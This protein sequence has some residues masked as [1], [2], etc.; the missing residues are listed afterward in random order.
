MIGQG[1]GPIPARIPLSLKLAYSA[2][3]A[4]LLPVYLANYG[5]TNFLYFCDIA[6]ILT[7][8][9]IWAES[10]LLVSI[11]AVG[12]LA[13]QLL[14]AVDFLAQAAGTPLTGMTAYMF[15]PDTSLFLRGL[16]LFHGWLPFLL[17]FLVWRLGYD[18]RAWA[19]W[20]A[21]AVILLF[22]C[23]FLMPPPRPDPGLTPVNINYVRGM[24]DT[25][26]QTFLPAWA[27]FAGLVVAIPFAIA[28]PTHRL[29]IWL[30]PRAPSTSAVTSAVMSPLASPA[31]SGPR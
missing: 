15:N 10:A 11:C 14:W 8:V 19:A 31:G 5:P 27:W 18:R 26:A 17:V 20:S 9:G 30:M 7:L 25:A 1:R 13:P 28:W 3:M 12:I 22:V 23:F 24:S 4:V 29:L 16:S 21:L 2:F 6:L